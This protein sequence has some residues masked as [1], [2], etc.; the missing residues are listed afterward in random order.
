MVNYIDC[1]LTVESSVMYHEHPRM[2]TRPGSQNTPAEVNV[3]SLATLDEHGVCASD[4]KLSTQSFTHM[5]APRHFFKDGLTIDELTVDRLVSEAAVFDLSHI[6]ANDAVDA[7]ELENADVD[8]REG[9]VA[10]LRTDW[11]D[12]AWGTERFWLDLP[13]LTED[14]AE[15]L[16]DEG[17][18][19]L[20]VDFFNETK[21]ITRK[22]ETC[23]NGWIVSDEDMSRPNHHLFLPNGVLLFEWLTNL[24]EISRERVTF[25]GLPLK[26]KGTDGSPIRAVVIEE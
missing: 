9:D 24:S 1:T 6:E 3:G 2:H 5:D 25:I 15:W 17:I 12:E 11:T 7:E 13:Y 19:G 23:G 22:C 26:L 20:G 8:L 4:F 16:M 18:S 21:P 14:G 10:I